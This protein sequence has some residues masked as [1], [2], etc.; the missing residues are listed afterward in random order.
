MTLTTALALVK[1]SVPPKWAEKKTPLEWK[2]ELQ[3]LQND[4][5]GDIQ[6]S[7]LVQ[8]YVTKLTPSY[9]TIID[10]YASMDPGVVWTFE[11][12]FKKANL[13]WSLRVRDRY[14][15]K[16]GGDEDDS[17]RKKR[18]KRKQRNRDNNDAVS[19]MFSAALSTAVF[20]NRCGKPGHIQK[21]CTVES[22]EKFCT[23][24]K[25]T[26]HWIHQCFELLK[27]K[28]NGK[29][30]GKGEK[31]KKGQRKPY[32]EKHYG[33]NNQIVPAPVPSRENSSA[34]AKSDDDNDGY[35]QGGWQMNMLHFVQPLP[36][37]W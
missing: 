33:L 4:C 11:N 29:G 2:E 12:A 15:G 28:K 36:R 19:G 1:S 20:C 35:D 3:A 14:T 32:Q 37:R 17:E 18:K 34:V 13:Y 6:E 27:K 25:K 23:N 21:D 30:K 22:V 5:G 16:N 31:G 9:D 8:R 26:N 10:Q 24:C 7:E